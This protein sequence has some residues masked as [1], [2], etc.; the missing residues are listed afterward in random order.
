LT[1]P[2]YGDLNHLVSATM[3]GVTTCLRT[4]VCDIPP[5]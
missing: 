5:R 4:A 3:S 2:T 1:T